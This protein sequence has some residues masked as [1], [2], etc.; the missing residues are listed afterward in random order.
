[1][2]AWAVHNTHTI[3]YV[4]WFGR[5]VHVVHGLVC[6]WVVV[7]KYVF[8]QVT[9]VNNICTYGCEQFVSAKTAS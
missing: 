7:T 2:H 5:M 3:E 1:M 9:E 6:V 4:Q 8:L